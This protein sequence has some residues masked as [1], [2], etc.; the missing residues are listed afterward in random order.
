MGAAAW[1]NFSIGVGGQVLTVRE[2]RSNRDVMAAPRV[3]GESVR[4]TTEMR[5]RSAVGA[6][7]NRYANSW[8]HI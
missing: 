4:R 1:R 7:G 8:D 2:Q 6:G 3:P 5:R